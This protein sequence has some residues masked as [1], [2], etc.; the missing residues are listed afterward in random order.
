MPCDQEERP[1]QVLFERQ[2]FTVM[3]P[4]EV[5]SETGLTQENV[6]ARMA[7]ATVADKPN[8]WK[9]TQG[10]FPK[11]FRCQGGPGHS[12]GR[13]WRDANKVSHVHVLR[14]M[15]HT[16]PQAIPDIV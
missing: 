16:R 12:E 1:F 2:T 3:G 7:R 13:E 9:A 8:V 6:E 4:P 15:W 14:A 10:G 11:L 5:K